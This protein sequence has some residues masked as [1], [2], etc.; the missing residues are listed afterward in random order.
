MVPTGVQSGRICKRLIFY[1]FLGFG[2]QHSENLV[3]ILIN[4]FS[5]SLIPEKDWDLQVSQELMLA[6]YH[7][8]GMLQSQNKPFDT[9]TEKWSN[10]TDGDKFMTR[11]CPFSLKS[12]ICSFLHQEMFVGKLTCALATPLF[13]PLPMLGV[14]LKITKDGGRGSFTQSC[15]QSYSFSWTIYP[16]N[17]MTF[18][19]GRVFCIPL[20]SRICKDEILPFLETAD[21][22]TVWIA[23]CFS[24]KG[25]SFCILAF[26]SLSYFFKNRIVYICGRLEEEGHVTFFSGYNKLF[27]PN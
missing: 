3:L 20:T 6:I 21:E 11:M 1:S 15:H 24:P 5:K 4:E 9:L 23:V 10:A 2:G 27:F 7:T 25:C 19:T 14:L 18:V 13:W 12:H 22:D 8:C 17:T 26:L 16:V